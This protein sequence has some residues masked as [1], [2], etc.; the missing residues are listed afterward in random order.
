[1][2]WEGSSNVIALDVARAI[3]REGAD[4]TLFGMLHQRLQSLQQPG[5]VPLA[6]QVQSSLHQLSER[7][8]RLH[9]LDLDSAQLPLRGLVE[10]MAQLTIMILLLEQAESE[11]LRAS[12]GTGMRKLLIANMYMRRH[13]LVHPDGWMAD[14][15]TC[16]LERMS[17]CRLNGGLT[18]STT[19]W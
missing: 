17:C 14:D 11:L 7:L 19:L 2:I 18:G 10:R 6:H 8:Q 15:D 5:V 12:E 13:V 16:E 3:T 1:V 4:T 9:T